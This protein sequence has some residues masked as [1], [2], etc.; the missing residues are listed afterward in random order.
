VSWANLFGVRAIAVLGPEAVEVP[1][2]N[3]D[4]ALSNAEGYEPFV[5]PFFRRGIMLLDFDEH[6]YHRRIMQAAF[7]RE[8]LVGYLDRM[9]P[10]IEG[11]PLRWAVVAAR[12]KLGAARAGYAGKGGKQPRQYRDL[13]VLPDGCGS[14]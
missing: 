6:L 12:S 13:R 2:R 14:G 7:T 10:V 9:N 1:L 4:K 11:V 8:R 5:G 3:R